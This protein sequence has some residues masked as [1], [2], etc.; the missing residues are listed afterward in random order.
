MDSLKVLIKKLQFGPAAFLSLAYNFAQRPLVVLQPSILP[1]KPPCLLNCCLQSGST[2]ILFPINFWFM[3]V[4][5]L[6]NLHRQKICGRASGRNGTLHIRWKLQTFV[7]KVRGKWFIGQNRY[8]VCTQY[9][10]YSD[11]TWG[12]FH[13]LI[14]QVYK[15]Y[16]QQA[17]IKKHQRNTETQLNRAVD[18]GWTREWTWRKK[19][20]R[21]K[22]QRH[23]KN[24]ESTHKTLSV[25]LK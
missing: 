20:R 4:L 23:H 16:G 6:Q 11:F 25:K 19:E 10:Q 21:R 1:I 17:N 15:L 5:Y 18:N 13:P 12:A 14:H 8:H 7:A 2:M 24:L 22:S 9:P 3:G